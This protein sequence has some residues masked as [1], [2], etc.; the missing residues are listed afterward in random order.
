MRRSARRVDIVMRQGSRATAR[1]RSR[2]ALLLALAASM[3][4][5]EIWIPANRVAA[6]TAAR[7]RDALATIRR[8]DPRIEMSPAG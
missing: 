4:K 5:F 2:A 7:Q 3:R 6:Q 1:G 8:F